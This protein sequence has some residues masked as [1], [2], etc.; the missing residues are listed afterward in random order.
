[1]TA[2]D[3]SLPSLPVRPAATPD[4]LHLPIAGMRCAGCVAGVEKA[5]GAVPGVRSVA[6]NLAAGRATVVMEPG[7]RPPV[8]QLVEAVAGAG[9]AVPRAT[10]T[11]AVGGMHCAACVG[12][13]EAALLAVPGVLAAAVNLP[14]GEARVEH[15][16]GL[17]RAGLGAAVSG[18]GF[19]VVT[20]AA[21]EDEV[22]VEER[23]RGEEQG[24]LRR[25]LLVAAAVTAA[26]MVASAALM[27][28]QPHH[29]HTAGLS[30]VAWLNA[31][32]EGMARLL[33]PWLWTLPLAALRWGLTA[34]ALP[35]W[36]WTAWPILRDGTVRAIRHRAPDMNT[37]IA[38][39][40]GAAVLA[41][42]A[43]T[44]APG[45]FQ[46]AGLTAHLYYEA[47]L[48]I[49]TLILLGRLLES[50]AKGRTSEAVRRLL[51]LAPPVARRIGDAGVEEEV[52][53]HSLAP[54]DRVRI[55]PG[56]RVPA[57]GVVL[58]GTSAV[59]E[60]MLTGEPVPAHKGPGD[61][62]VGATVNG[63][64]SL[65]MLVERTGNDTVLAQIVRLVRQAQASKAPVQR[66]ADRVAAVFVPAV[67]LLA[68]ATLVAWL[69]FGPEQRG[70]YAFT[71]AV[72][73]LVI[74]CPCA[75]GLATPTALAVGTGRGAEL[76]ILITSAAALERA[77]QVRT[78]VLDKTGTLTAG[79]PE[80]VGIELVGDDG[81]VLP[82]VAGAET[83]SEHPLARAVVEGLAARGVAS[84]A[85]SDVHAVP[86]RGLRARSEGR[87]AGGQPGVPR[88]GGGSRR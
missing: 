9:F 49:V 2:P 39:G 65:L 83:H 81:G 27:A 31:P 42:L 34:V 6:V 77:A 60:A 63:Q 16:A 78:V 7:H 51:R 38:L 4:A 13:L 5:L 1:M 45:V 32:M 46:T 66:L 85:V 75:L 56:G 29:G 10:T 61:R 30:L 54:G 19:E 47:A 55:L 23:L 43:G 36:V 86:G 20:P 71:A 18:A 14:A 70:L 24:E 40:T 11:L 88:R 74:A 15:V 12:R 76:G 82:L 68:A 80:L 44:L 17:D 8:T 57:D 28:R 67:L 72:S 25:R 22:A 62:V 73:V 53:V 3:L 37:L 79:R 21:G 50:G 87:V 35:A 48:M 64:G 69:I 33:A 84:A 52:P 26:V 58:Q 41:S 59:D